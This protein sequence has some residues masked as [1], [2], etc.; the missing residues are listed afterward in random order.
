MED[1]IRELEKALLRL[2]RN[3]A[4]E[5]VK[6]GLQ[7]ARIKALEATVKAL[8]EDDMALAKGLGVIHRRTK[9]PR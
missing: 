6:N 7:D 3:I 5:K 1:R 8:A 2:E 4:A 9:I